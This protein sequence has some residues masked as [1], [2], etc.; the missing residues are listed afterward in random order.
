MYEPGEQMLELVRSE[1][2]AVLGCPIE[3]VPA[4][5]P[6]ADLG[7][8]SL[9]ALELADRL[10]AATGAALP[11][12]LAFDYPTP[13]ALAAYLIGMEKPEQIAEKADRFHEEPIAIV[14]MSCRYPG[15]VAT[16][17]EFW[18]LLSAG[19]DAIG[20]FPDDR[21]WDTGIYDPDGDRPGSSYVRHGGFL[22]GAGDFDTSF[23]GLSPRDA[24]ATDPQQRLML[25]L[26]W[27]ALERA[28]ITPHN[29]R[30][31]DTGVFTGVIASDY[32]TRI[33]DLPAETD[34][35]VLVGNAPSVVSGR[36]AYTLGLEGP[37]LS[38]DTAC[39]SSLVALHLAVR[40]LRA[41]ECSLA[42]AGGVTVLGSP[43]VF[44]EFSRQR[45][46]APDGRC[47]S[48]AAAADGTGWAEGAGVLLLERLSDARRHGHPVLAL[49]R[50]S[51]VNSDGAS[52]GLTAPNGPAQ[53][54]LIRLALGD[55]GLRPSDVDAI[56][57]HGTGT[58]LGD[59]IEAQALQA[60][61]GH[62]RERPLWVGSVKSNIG[63]AQAAA[64]VAGVIK[65]VLS[66]H[67]GQLPRTLHVDEP[68]PFV[69]WSLGRLELLTSARAWPAADEPR[70]AA[71]SS[72]GISG[73]NAHVIL[74]EAPP[75]GPPARP[76]GRGVTPLPLSARTETALRAQ[77]RRWADHLAQH[78]GLWPD[79][80][81]AAAV[82][83]TS[84]ERRAVV[85]D[86]AGLGALAEGTPTP[87]V[88]T[89][90]ASEGR[91][92]LLFPGQGAQRV[93]MGRELAKAVP[94]FAAAMDEICAELDRHLDRPMRSII[95]G[96]ADLLEQTG[97]TQPA[98]FAIEAAL[99]R[100]I[101]AWGVKPG[102]LL[103]HSIGELTAAYA[104]G[105]LSLVDACRLVA[106]RGGLM[107]ALP[108]IGAMVAIQ[109]TPDEVSP[110]L[111][112]DVALAAV[113]GPRSVVVS[114]TR[115][116]TDRL[117]AAF[118]E[119]GRR[120]TRLRVSHAFHS[121]LM[122]PMLAELSAVERDTSARESAIPVVSNVTALP[123]TTIEP[124]YW[125][126]HAREPVQFARSI[127]WLREQGVTNFLE[128]GPGGVLSGM[129][130]DCLGESG[131][132]SAAIPLL[133]QGR[134]EVESVLE[135]LARLHVRGPAVD[136]GV[137][138]RGP[139]HRAA[140][141]PTYPFQRRRFWLGAGSHALLPTAV[142]L[143][144]PDGEQSVALTGRLSRQAQPWLTDHAINQTVILPSTAFAEIA[145]QAGDRVGVPHVEQLSIE[146]P[147]ILPEHGE[148]ALR[149]VVTAEP[150]GRWRLAIHGRTEPGGWIRHATG[151]LTAQSPGGTARLKLW[152]PPGAVEADVAGLYSRMADR[153]YDYGPAFRCLRRAWTRGEEVF[154]E[155]SLP[156]GLAEQ[157]SRY[158]IHPA[159]LD[160]ALHALGLDGEDTVVP[161]HWT[162]LTVYSAGATGL[163]VRLTRQGGTASLALAD[164]TGTPVGTGVV[165][166]R[167]VAT[168]RKRAGYSVAWRPVDAVE[169][170]P[171]SVTWL[172]EIGE[173]VPETVFVRAPSNVEHALLLIQRWLADFTAARL[174][175][176][177]R[178]GDLAHAAVWGLVRSAQSEHPGRFALIDTD[179]DV[180]LAEAAAT[181]EPQL[182]VRDGLLTVPRLVPAAHVDEARPWDPEGTVLIT[183]GTGALGLLIARHLVSARGVRHVLLVSRG[184]MS[185][186][187]EELPEPIRVA[188]CD[189]ADPRALAELLASIP[190]EH[191]L[192]AVLH[193]AGVL[194]DAVVEAQTPERIGAVMRPKAGA[195]WHLHELT[196]DLDLAAF[197]CFSSAA[198]ILGSPG[199]SGYSAA[200]AYLDALALHRRELGLPGQSL[201]WGLWDLPDGM[202]AALDPGALRRMRRVGLP[203]MSPERGL[204][205]FD[206]AIESAAPLLVLA[207]VDTAQ[208]ATQT[209]WA[210]PAPLRELVV[211]R[212]VA[213]AAAE[214]EVELSGLPREEQDRVLRE[215]V[216]TEV[217]RVLGHASPSE[218]D[219]SRS[220]ADLGFDSLT[221]V[222]LRNRLAA[223]TG[224]RLA[225]TVA[226]DHPSIPA[227]VTHLRAELAPENATTAL[228]VLADL[229]RLESAVAELT[230]DGVTRMR[231]A[232]SLTRLL[233]TV[234]RRA[235]VIAA[236]QDDFFDLTG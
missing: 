94:E 29:L 185:K 35:F 65:L 191:P 122:E 136:W 158:R 22:D 221:A 190:A 68:T 169:P 212:A 74:E 197:I 105:A 130:L 156:A 62:G 173:H 4:D 155:V 140:A 84:F 40:A 95:D 187:E 137:V 25:E 13:A 18:E 78:P 204:A 224:L 127:G 193:L 96:D 228:G 218:V 201:A 186:V 147:L 235:D 209:G 150:D 208:M 118:A 15:G 152:P 181:G 79:E 83:R 59:P 168:A 90:T 8:D 164:Q 38:V 82:R 1:A 111:D 210:V 189:A 182:A 34:G 87:A 36:V 109:A 28:G 199:Q 6:F 102:F 184:G 70:R 17:E 66:L 202:T 114:G 47:K 42:L 71:V 117:A 31:S 200:N 108:P 2:A 103:G 206:S 157:A 64:G 232:E 39:S 167:P 14:S 183:G 124:G 27:E 99:F 23:F 214:A 229:T 10:T 26:S 49:I 171:G 223:A 121:P 231:L 115:E 236:A 188:A 91:L 163:R 58:R 123:M 133:A 53:Q 233:S 56:E 194:D 174:V 225:A 125:V 107:Q 33:A 146:E 73:T 100:L 19:R 7:F 85:F 205:L 176:V 55:A 149:A 16:P 128:V 215:L 120:T 129:T 43:L 57:A 144:G 63:H 159:L 207:D 198:S 219:T 93:G 37:A 139:W 97:Y 106:A 195:A 60:V 9:T 54:R 116:A 227:L 162:D 177:T 178:P 113:N 110:L 98:M 222:E 203:A 30:G 192:T 165:A 69:D 143:P 112:G 153:G 32:A 179:E 77:A 67:N 172:D 151:R 234:E 41:G 80:V 175:L 101:Q 51:A 50:G 21:G 88:I 134:G 89:G 119:Q 86:P 131:V 220:M 142:E 72:F 104:G 75:A 3:D 20:P 46:L 213:K 11:G 92:A 161:F 44:T 76:T 230:M 81:A 5:R 24:L 61:Y 226:F 217:A 135:A 160:A 211:P 196:K 48:F 148:I 216:L 126:R 145:L 170:Q 132:D 141:L 166:L 138:N 52:N 154:A 45:G 180:L 12:T